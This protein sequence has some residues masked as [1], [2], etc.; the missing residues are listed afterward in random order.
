MAVA[1]GI[2]NPVFIPASAA[3]GAAGDDGTASTGTAP[4]A[5]APTRGIR[6]NTDYHQSLYGVDQLT[7]KGIESFVLLT[8]DLAPSAEEKK[9]K[10]MEAAISATLKQVTAVKA[11][12][13]DTSNLEAKVAE[14]Q[15][16]LLESFN[17]LFDF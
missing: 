2:G 17:S 5:A 1:G 12:G 16:K 11:N 9:Q 6:R 13:M 3:G 15:A 7:V 4:A 8:R 14:M 10:A